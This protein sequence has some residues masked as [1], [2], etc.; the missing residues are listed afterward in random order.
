MF[1]KKNDIIPL[2]DLNRGWWTE[3][4]DNPYFVIAEENPAI[5]LPFKEKYPTFSN[6]PFLTLNKLIIEISETICKCP[7]LEIVFS[8]QY[9]KCYLDKPGLTTEDLKSYERIF[10][11]E[12]T[13][14][15]H[16]QRP[17]LLFINEDLTGVD[18]IE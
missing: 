7:A 12:G 16:G 9:L 15:L 11:S 2:R 1:L 6:N 5:I 13:L 17:Y 18:L 4:S 3:V 14:E 10:D 8:G